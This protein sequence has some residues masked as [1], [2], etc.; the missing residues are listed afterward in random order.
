MQKLCS[1]ESVQCRKEEDEDLQS[2][3]RSGHHEYLSAP[4][5]CRRGH[6][7]VLEAV[8]TASRLGCETEG[9]AG[10]CKQCEQVT[11]DLRQGMARQEGGVVKMVAGIQQQM[12][13]Q[14]GWLRV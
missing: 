14:V 4:V 3:A 10:C 8:H 5:G 2:A 6:W 7:E 1:T 11:A 13:W 12:A 9:S